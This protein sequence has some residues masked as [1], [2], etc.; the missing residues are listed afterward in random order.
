MFN[1]NKKDEEQG[2]KRKDRYTTEKETPTAPRMIREFFNKTTSPTIFMALLFFM[3]SFP[4]SV[5]LNYPSYNAFLLSPV[6]KMTTVE[7]FFQGFFFTI[8]EW[9]PS[10]QA[11]FK[12]TVATDIPVNLTLRWWM[13]GVG[14]LSFFMVRECQKEARDGVD[15]VELSGE[16]VWFGFFLAI[17]SFDQI[18]GLMLTFVCGLDLISSMFSL[19]SIK[20]GLMPKIMDDDALAL[21]ELM[22]EAG[23]EAAGLTAYLD[24]LDED[25]IEEINEHEEDDDDEEEEGK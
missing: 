21:L 17:A 10:L 5:V 1:R 9:F 11:A 2:G 12:V 14:M 3:V 18:Y 15:G 8:L 19:S 7:G 22:E 4:L 25:S 20:K 24:T 13:V 23:V 16:V 6:I